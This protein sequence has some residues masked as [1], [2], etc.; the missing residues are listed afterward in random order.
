M[1]YLFLLGHAIKAF[2][3]DL[4]ACSHKH[5]GHLLD[6]RLVFARYWLY[7]I[8]LNPIRCVFWI[9]VGW[10]LGFIISQQDIRLKVQAIQSLQ[11]NDNFLCHFLPNYATQAHGFLHLLY[12][13]I[14]FE[15]ESYMQEYFDAL[16]L[17]LTQAP[18]ISPLGFTKDFILYI[19]TYTYAV[20]SVL[21]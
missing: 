12:Q 10:L 17:V 13:T 6:L 14:P 16:K 5:S 20:A 9:T 19:S 4:I 2:L 18:L 21:I 7:N 8:H 11:G 3:D 15:L 1:G